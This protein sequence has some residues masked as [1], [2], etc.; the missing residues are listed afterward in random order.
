MQRLFI[1]LLAAIL[2]SPLLGGCASTPV[3]KSDVQE[4]LEETTGS[5]ITYVTTAAA[6][7]S[8][9]PGLASGGRDYVYLAPILVSRGGDHTCWLWLGVWSTIDRQARNADVKPLKLG[10][11][12]IVA[13]DEPM[14]LDPQFADSHPTGVRQIPY[15][16]PV[17]PIQEF[18]VPVTRTQL[19]RLGSARVLTLVD[20]QEGEASRSWRGDGRAAS[21][22]SQLAEEAGAPGMNAAPVTGR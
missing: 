6:F 12:Q 13:D 22:L 17:P 20:R 7:V 18:L 2:L 16:T 9:Q 1:Q 8:D 19:Q 11:L 14:D 3:A 15:A 21:L 5:N 10:A 4:S